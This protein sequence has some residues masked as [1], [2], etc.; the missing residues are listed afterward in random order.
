MSDIS[1]K[2]LLIFTGGC[3][4][5]RGH[6]TKISR[7]VLTKRPTACGKGICNAIMSPVVI[8]SPPPPP[9]C[10]SV[11]CLGEGEERE[12]QS[13]HHSTVNMGQSSPAE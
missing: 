5:C 11:E 6:Q 4:E 1:Y 9:M 7:G 12:R 8:V 3:C 10:V 13:A 2:M